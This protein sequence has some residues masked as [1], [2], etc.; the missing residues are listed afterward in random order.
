MSLD[1]NVWREYVNVECIEIIKRNVA[2]VFHATLILHNIKTAKMM[3][4]CGC[5]ADA[6]PKNCTFV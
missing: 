6:Q 2:D 4:L 3:G 1:S 5:A